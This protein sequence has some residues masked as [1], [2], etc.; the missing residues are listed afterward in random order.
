MTEWI[1]VLNK[2]SFGSAAYPDFV[3]LHRDIFLKKIKNDYL[4]KKCG[5]GGRAKA[6]PAPLVAPPL[7]IIVAGNNSKEFF[8]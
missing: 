1:Y 8:T 2:I 5:G 3:C 7:L 6:P 4:T